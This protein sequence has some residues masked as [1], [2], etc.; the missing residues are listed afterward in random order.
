MLSALLTPLTAVVILYIAYQQLHTNRLRLKFELFDRRYKLYEKVTSFL[1]NI[2]VEGT[3][4]P[5]APT[6]YLPETKGVIFLFDKRIQ[7]FAE[8]VYHKASDLHTLGTMGE[9]LDGGPLS[10]NLDKQHEN[11]RKETLR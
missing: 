1:A 8:E 2:L 5:N 10:R 9:R 11:K 7:E 6:N 4:S 3:V